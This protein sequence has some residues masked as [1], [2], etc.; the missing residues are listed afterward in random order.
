MAFAEERGRLS[1][2]SAQPVFFADDLGPLL[3][4]THLGETKVQLNP[5]RESRITFGY[6]TA[7]WDA[8]N[9]PTKYWLCKDRRFGFYRT[10]REVDDTPWVQFR[11]AGQ[12]AA[13]ASGFH[14]LVAAQLI[15]AI[16]EMWSNIHEHSGASETG[17]IAFK[18]APGAFEFVVSDRGVGVLNS[19]KTSS[20]HAMVRDD[21]TALRL[22][23]TDGVS[24][25]GSGT[26]HGTGFRPLF[27]G[28]A[29]LKS[30]LRFRSGTSAL[31]IDGCNPTLVTARIAQKPHLG[32]FFASVAC[33]ANRP[34]T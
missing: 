22:A 8:L 9:S 1:R 14:R 6:M 25:H 28:L 29:N 24:R 27:V 3:E 19:L 12:Q 5:N 11:L 21:G 18:A 17:M 2:D 23:L 13:V 31:T 16:G 4:L 30:S 33:R 15:G 20:E 32:G 7:F 10:A 26:G 34:K